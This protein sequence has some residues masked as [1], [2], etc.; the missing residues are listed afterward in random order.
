M[1]PPSILNKF[2]L[3]VVLHTVYIKIAAQFHAQTENEQHGSSLKQNL[4][5][6]VL[7]TPSS[8]SMPMRGSLSSLTLY[9]CLFSSSVR[10]LSCTSLYTCLSGRDLQLLTVATELMEELSSASGERSGKFYRKMERYVLKN[11]TLA[12]K[13]SMTN[14]DT[15]LGILW[16]WIIE[17]FTLQQQLMVQHQ[18]AGNCM[19]GCV[20]FLV[21]WEDGVSKSW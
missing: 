19:A 6:L 14:L 5:T 3:Q 9:C 1:F 13:A 12:S 15:F 16:N 18:L 21:W 2:S 7:F 17:Y 20:A 10:N 8:S 11:P 4:P